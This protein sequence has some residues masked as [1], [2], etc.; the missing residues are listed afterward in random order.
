MTR[1]LDV[2]RYDVPR[3]TASVKAHGELE[4]CRL[5]LARL[6]RVWD[7]V[8]LVDS[9]ESVWFLAKWSDVNPESVEAHY[10]QLLRYGWLRVTIGVAASFLRCCITSGCSLDCQQTS[11]ST[12]C[13]SRCAQDC[14]PC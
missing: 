9:M 4:A 10:Q 14:K 6:K 7:V 1:G 12:T 3:S 13:S 11:G 2:G 5:E 8:S